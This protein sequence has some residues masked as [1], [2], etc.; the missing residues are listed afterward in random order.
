MTDQAPLDQKEEL[1][2]KY[3]SL[4]DLS[5]FNTNINYFL[6]IVGSSGVAAYKD[7]LNR[8]KKEREPQK[9]AGLLGK[10]YQEI[11]GD[12]MYGL[13]ELALAGQTINDNEVYKRFL[14][15]GAEIFQ[16]RYNPQEVDLN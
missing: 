4:K 6:K 2:I 12:V 13:G 15:E 1:F 8:I 10:L 14:K 16:R 11:S 5:N 9:F 7:K 3:E